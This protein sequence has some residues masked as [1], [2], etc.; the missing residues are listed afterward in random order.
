MTEGLGKVRTSNPLTNERHGTVRLVAHSADHLSD[1]ILR[2]QVEAP[3][4]I[5]CRLSVLHWKDEFNRFAPK[6]SY[7]ACQCD[8][9]KLKHNADTRLHV[10]RLSRR[11]D[12][13]L[14]HHHGTT[15][16]TRKFAYWK[17]CTN[18]KPALVLT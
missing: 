6:V 9:A 13:A 18:V 1:I 14:S 2:V 3:F 12:S 8:N 17:V 10:P 16:Q 15:S 5:V 4:L 7:S 11:T